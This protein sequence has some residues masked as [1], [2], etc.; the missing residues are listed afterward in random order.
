MVPNASSTYTSQSDASSREKASSLASSSAWK[1]RFSSRS[2]WPSRS[3]AT[4]LRTP[5]PTQSS[6]K[7]TSCPKSCE[8]RSPAGS[9]D[10]SG[11]TLPSGLPRCEARITLARLPSACLMVG[12]AARMR[13]SSL[14]L[15]VFLS[16]GTL[17]STRTKRRRP[18]MS[19]C[20]MERIIPP[21]LQLAADVQRHVHHAVG[22]APLVVVPGEDLH[23]L[24]VVRHRGLGGVE[25]RRRWI[26]VVVDADGGLGV[27]LE[28]ALELALRRRLEGRVDLL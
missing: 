22:E 13:A 15:W 7:I 2:T 9:S 23:E 6:A 16:S 10:I 8:S 21:G 25:D 11:T 12:S 18:P 14:T 3:S 1:R 28:D 27:V 26:A 19:S 17:K 20:S 5:S 4:S 24:P